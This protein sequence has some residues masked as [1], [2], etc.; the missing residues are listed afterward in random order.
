MLYHLLLDDFVQGR[1][2]IVCPEM[3]LRQEGTETPIIFKGS[4]AIRSGSD[5]VVRLS[6]ISRDT[7]AATANVRYTMSREGGK[8]GELLPD[9]GYYSLSAMDLSGSIWES[10]RLSIAQRSDVGGVHISGDIPI[11]ESTAPTEI[12]SA[13]LMLH[14]VEDVEVPWNTTVETSTKV[15]G[16][17]E[18]SSLGTHAARFN[19]GSYEFTIIQE[20]GGILVR[21]NTL[22]KALPSN[23]AMRVIESLG[24]VTGQRIS[25]GFLEK[26]SEGFTTLSVRSLRPDDPENALEQP[27]CY[28]QHDRLGDCAWRLFSAYLQHTVRWPCDDPLRRH[29]VSAWLNYVR[30]ASAGSIFAKGLA[31]GVAVEGIL[32]AEFSGVGEPTDE[33]VRAVDAAIEYAKS[34]HGHSGVKRRVVGA[35]GAMRRP[36]AKDRLYGLVND[37]AISR[38]DVDA[39][40]TI[41]NKGAHARPPEEDE[42]QEWITAC[43]RVQILLHQLIFRAIE[44]EG[45][46]TDYGAENWP[47]AEY[48][49]P[50]GDDEVLDTVIETD[51][52]SET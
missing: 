2:E 15:G 26:Y 43:Y 31:L 38:R 17:R 5:H 46:Y 40:D 13:S 39:W 27:V 21:M 4:G 11:M 35:V 18:R 14:V 48:P 34:W 24:F 30:R 6:L 16:R 37:G 41:R 20:Q 49:P 8:P 19:V 44:Y 45:I 28:P 52:A 50:R 47:T 22:D 9:E 32:A 33:Y 42:Y 1:L 7:D 25:C 12:E 3:T 51:V 29:P 23:M 36:R 10:R